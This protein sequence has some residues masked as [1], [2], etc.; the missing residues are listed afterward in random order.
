MN[1]QLEDGAVLSGCHIFHIVQSHPH[2]S[3][4]DNQESIPFESYCKEIVIFSSYRIL[5]EFV[6]TEAFILM[7]YRNAHSAQG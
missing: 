7:V 2:A 3:S 1:R 6:Q 4:L 5:L